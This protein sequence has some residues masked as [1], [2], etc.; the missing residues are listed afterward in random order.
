M[1]CPYIFG[2]NSFAGTDEMRIGMYRR[3][4]TSLY[5]TDLIDKIWIVGKFWERVYVD[6]EGL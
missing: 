6:C 4:F 5:E 1:E 2:N 3:E